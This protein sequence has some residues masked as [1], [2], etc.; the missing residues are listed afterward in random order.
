ME[1]ATILLVDDV[2]TSGSQLQHVARRL[3]ASG[4]AEARGLVLARVPWGN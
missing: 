2:L 1:G 4:A 3:I